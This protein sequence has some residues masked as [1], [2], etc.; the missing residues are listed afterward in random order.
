MKSQAGILRRIVINTKGAT[1]NTLTIYDNTSAS[2]T[3]I[4][5]IDTTV[6][7]GAINFECNFSTG[8]TVVTATG[9]C[10]DV[11]VVYS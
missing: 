10:A 3:K 4:G 1:G 9:T 7:P 6:S 2:G 8:L 11:T 5:T